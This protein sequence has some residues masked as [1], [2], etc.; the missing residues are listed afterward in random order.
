MAT[1]R[2][3]IEYVLLCSVD[4]EVVEDDWARHAAAVYAALGVRVAPERCKSLY[5]RAIAEGGTRTSA[6]VAR[7]DALT[8][9]AAAIDPRPHAGLGAAPGAVAT[10]AADGVI[11]VQALQSAL[12]S[13]L[14]VYGADTFR[15]PV[16]PG[17]IMNYGGAELGPY[18]NV[19]LR[20]A[21]LEAMRAE[22]ASGAICRSGAACAYLRRV[23]ANCVMFNAPE[24]DF[25]PLARG[26]ATAAVA[27]FT[28]SLQTSTGN[29]P[30]TIK[31]EEGG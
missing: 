5:F 7:R 22:I 18:G 26:F 8:S 24:A 25:S 4:A 27:E 19:V 31:R 10:G 6:A 14:S 1:L 29:R 21:S 2:T 9:A 12:G 20:P 16:A 30:A 17:V 13:V 28:S 15:N 11:E 3:A 23:A